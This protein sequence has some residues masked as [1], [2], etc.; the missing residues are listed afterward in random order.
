MIMPSLPTLPKDV[1]LV[2]DDPDIRG[3]LKIFLKRSGYFVECAENGTDGL[4]LFQTRRWSVVISDRFMPTMG[5]EEMATHM[6]EL[7]TDVPIVLMTAAP[8][9]LFNPEMFNAIL[10]KPFRLD[11]L[12]AYL[13]E[14]VRDKD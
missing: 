10:E 2:D 11:E 6:R 3:V 13:D 7:Q 1:L 14:I 8:D 12:A 4:N 5:G 9:G